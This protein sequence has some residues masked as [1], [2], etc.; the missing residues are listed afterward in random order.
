MIRP[1]QASKNLREK[2]VRCNNNY[3]DIIVIA[4]FFDRKVLESAMNELKKGSNS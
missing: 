4:N 3:Y 2:T 1:K